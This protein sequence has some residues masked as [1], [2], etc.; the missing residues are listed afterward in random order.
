M[1]TN[2]SSHQRGLARKR[3]SETGSDV[4]DASPRRY[5]DGVG[6]VGD[7]QLGEHVLQ[8]SLHGFLGESEFTGNLPVSLSNRYKAQDLGFTPG[9][10]LVDDVK[11]D[12]VGDTTMDVT[13][14]P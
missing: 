6:T 13:L 8:V 3:R 11:C 12:L 5:G 9:K 2:V 4:D 14:P 1:R 10:W 7:A